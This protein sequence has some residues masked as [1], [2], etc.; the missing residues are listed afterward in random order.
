VVQTKLGVRPVTG[1]F[2][3]RTLAA[4]QAY[5]RRVGLRATGVVDGWT[6]FRLGVGPNPSPAPPARSARPYARLNDSGA[7]VRV[8]QTKMG[9]KPVDG[10]FG[11]K[12][13][14]AVQAYQRRLGLRT[15][16]VVDG[17]T[18]YRL[19]VG[20]SPAAKPASTPAAPST[21]TAPYA[22]PGDTG[23]RVQAVQTKLGVRPATGYY[24]TLTTA[25]VRAYQV[26]YHLP[27][28]GVVDRATATRLGLVR[29]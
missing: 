4:V 15:T 28:T 6:A 8:V 11:P 3:A 18:A 19:G 9:V 5:Q 22:K 17:W 10:L 21:S 29:S 16:G 14:A 25:A 13:L 23:A 24:G 20:P 2:G 26:R 1:F 7:H 27:V 12:T